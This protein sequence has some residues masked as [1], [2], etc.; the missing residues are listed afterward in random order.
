MGRRHDVGGLRDFVLP[1][2]LGDAEPFHADW[3]AHVFA[4][5]RAL[6]RQHVLVLDEVRNVDRACAHLGAQGDEVFHGCGFSS[7][8]AHRTPLATSKDSMA[9][10][11]RS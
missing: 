11:Q 6:I 4:M 5:M 1:D 9:S 2:D 10:S 3:E 7:S 8:C